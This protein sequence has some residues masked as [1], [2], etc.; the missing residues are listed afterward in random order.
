MKRIP[1]ANDSLSIAL[2]ENALRVTLV[3]S[4]ASGDGAADRSCSQQLAAT[5][6]PSPMARHVGAIWVSRLVVAFWR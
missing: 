6:A 4:G 1:S 2:Q 3:E 5:A